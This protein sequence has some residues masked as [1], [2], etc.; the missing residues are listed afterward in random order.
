MK[1]LI[2]AGKQ[3][4]R[5][6]ASVPAS[7][8]NTG[9]ADN[10]DQEDDSAADAPI[11]S[12][13]WMSVCRRAVNKTM[14]RA[15]RGALSLSLSLFLAMTIRS[16]TRSARVQTSGSATDETTSETDGSPTTGDLGRGE[17]MSEVAESSPGP[18]RSPHRRWVPLKPRLHRR[19][20]TTR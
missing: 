11:S 12:Q 10:D 14:R 8:A 5:N 20:P 7:D 19:R 13:R 6:S 1:R 9:C 16:A 15:R 2:R 18:A 17:E 4:R 3:R